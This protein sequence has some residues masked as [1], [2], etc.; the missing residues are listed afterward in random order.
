MAILETIIGL[1]LL[2]VIGNVLSHFLKRVP[3]SLIQITLGLFI[4]V[5]FGVKINL[6]SH[7]FM[8]LFVAPLLYSDAWNFP[9]RELWNLK[10]PIFGNAILLVF[11][12]TIIGGYGIYWL[13]PSMPLSVAFAIAAILSPTDPVAVASIGQE[14]KLPPALMHLVS[15]ESLIND[16]SGLVA[17]KFA[18]AATVS[19]TF[20]LA[21]ATSDFLYTTLVG[22]VV[23]IV[24]GLL[25][26]RLQSWLMQEQATNA[27]VNVVTNILTPFLIYQIAEGVHA[28]GVIAVVIAAIVQ[29]LQVKGN[30][31]TSGE[32]YLVNRTTW[33][34][35]SYLMNG[36]IFILLG[37]ELPV[38]IN[39]HAD[40]NQLVPISMLFLYAF[41]TWFLI[42]MIRVVWS[43]LNQIWEKRR[44]KST[45]LSW[46]NAFMAGLTGVRG[47]VTMAGV[48]SVPA[49]ID[50]GTPFP[51]RSM[52]LFIAAMVIVISLLAAIVLLPLLA[53]PSKP[54]KK[55]TVPL[56]VAKH[57]SEPRAYTYVLQTA[58]GEL[59]H[60]LKGS[61]ASIVYDVL[62]AYYTKIRRIQ[63]RS[64]QEEKLQKILRTELKFRMI[65]LNAQR[66]ALTQLHAEHQISSLVYDS[67]NRRLDR[68]EDDLS[69][70][71]RVRS[72]RQNKFNLEHL[73][74]KAVR[75]I[76]VWVNH[77][78]SDA[79]RAEYELA[80]Q[81][82]AQ[83]G[84][85]AMT[86]YAQ[87]H[88]GSMNRTETTA[89]KHL[90]VLF[91]SRLANQHRNVKTVN[92]KSTKV[93]RRELALK[94]YT[95]Q[96]SALEHLYEAGFIDE[97]SAVKI[98]QNINLD[99]ASYLAQDSE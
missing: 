42:F 61:N 88:A 16:A 93:L 95:A 72:Q 40:N 96:R 1:T 44:V 64:L 20:S 18:I 92:K 6:D 38:A 75:A 13:I 97:Q 84:L 4:A 30:R 27:V 10:G 50:S 57:M 69:Q 58:V 49:F 89:I 91:H 11:L 17:F 94:G 73:W 28:S 21:H 90:K 24:L 76:R 47:A 33:Q 74:R 29:N 86:D 71:V 37:I 59:E 83:A 25:M 45:V 80:A 52:M 48:L 32:Y 46:K 77:T 39:V 2:V 14:T 23:G 36:F 26:T 43:Y 56:D 12:T 98:R 70:T 53:K 65:A 81:A 3:V 68:I 60:E 15:G 34:V 99:E 41:L 8:L 51:E 54:K 5:F 19:G 63:M 31:A 55:M 78:D 62:T 35:F 7:W 9:K 85:T 66:E 22:A 82:T 79:L 87:L 67:E